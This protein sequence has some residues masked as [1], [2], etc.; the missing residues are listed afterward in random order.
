MIF[1]Q[2]IYQGYVDL[3]AMSDETSKYALHR[4][5]WCVMYA[6]MHGTKQ[7]PDFFQFSLPIESTRFDSLDNAKHFSIREK[8]QLCFYDLFEIYR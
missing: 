3:F 5:L 1:C 6:A 4:R 2:Y 7:V 8:L